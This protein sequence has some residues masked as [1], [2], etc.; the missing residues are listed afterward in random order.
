[1]NSPFYLRKGETKAVRTHFRSKSHD[2]IQTLN[3]NPNLNFAHIC[4]D[5]DKIKK[6]KQRRGFER[7]SKQRKQMEQNGEKNLR[8][9]T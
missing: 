7:L 9:K 4:Q 2:S 1:M 5:E 8:D 3:L 6:K